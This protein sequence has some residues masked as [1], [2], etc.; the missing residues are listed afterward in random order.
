VFIVI[1]LVSDKKTIQLIKSGLDSKKVEHPAVRVDNWVYNA[2]IFRNLSLCP[3][4]FKPS[5]DIINYLYCDSYKDFLKTYD[6][7]K[8]SFVFDTFRRYKHYALHYTL[9]DKDYYFTVS[10]NSERGMDII[11]Y[12]HMLDSDYDLSAWS[13]ID[14]PLYLNYATI[15]YSFLSELY[16]DILNH[17]FDTADLN[18]ILSYFKKSYRNSSGTIDIL[19]KFEKSRDMT[20]IM[21]LL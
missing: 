17:L 18:S 9:N 15:M 5:A 16:H 20:L 1:N 13:S 21:P 12:P 11:F 4:G 3:D 19:T 2:E 10:Y 14:S 6:I 7:T 8:T